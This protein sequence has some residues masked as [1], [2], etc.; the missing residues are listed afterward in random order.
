M[1]KNSIGFN[2]S[3]L[4]SREFQFPT[5]IRQ[6][7][8]LFIAFL[9]LD[10]FLNDAYKAKLNKFQGICYG[11]YCYSRIKKAFTDSGTS[12]IHGPR[13]AVHKLFARMGVNNSDNTLPC[14]AEIRPLVLKIGRKKYLLP[15]IMNEK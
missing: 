1:A 4:G 2:S 3:S 15:K 12:M 11:R 7:F 14:N 5:K 10:F 6:F 13:V 8:I 9:L